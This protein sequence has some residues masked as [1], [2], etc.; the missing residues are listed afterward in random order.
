MSASNRRYVI[1]PALLAMFLTA[2]LYHGPPGRSTSKTIQ[3][4]TDNQKTVSGLIS[5]A[6]P[7]AQDVREEDRK[8]LDG[9]AEKQNQDESSPVENLADAETI[10]SNRNSV[11]RAELVV[12][13]EVVRRAELVGH[14]GRVKRKRQSITQ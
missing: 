6:S 8:F 1:L 14:D 5:K 10:D 9:L 4:R 11:P 13:S 12:N 2:W 3:E 7:E